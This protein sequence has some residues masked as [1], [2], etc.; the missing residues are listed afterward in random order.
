MTASGII[1]GTTGSFSNIRCPGTLNGGFGTF[2]SLN[3][4]SITATGSISAVAFTS[5]SDYR[6]KGNITELDHSFNVDKLRPVTYINNLSNNQ[7]IGLIAHELQE[8]Y[9][10]LVHGDK[11]GIDIQSVNY[12]GIVGI[13][14]NEIKILKKRVSTLEEQ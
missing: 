2:N 14:I 12:I 5:T 9:P 3:I 10:F 8:Q 6:I 7:D 11:D 13:L 4:G 1:S